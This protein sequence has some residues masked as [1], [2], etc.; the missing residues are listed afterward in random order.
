MDGEVVG[1]LQ[2]IPAKPIGFIDFMA[3]DKSL[4]H[5]TRGWVLKKFEAQSY[6][7][8]KT[9][10][11]QAAGYFIPFELKSFKRILKKRGAAVIA[12]GNMMM[13]FV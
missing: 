8:L 2:V 11:C 12:S 7:T 4:P 6:A 9:A 1:T 13:R 3:V 10:G 5:T